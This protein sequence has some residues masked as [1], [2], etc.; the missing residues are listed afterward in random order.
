MNMTKKDEVYQYLKKLLEQGTPE[1]K[2]FNLTI[3]DL[4]EVDE[5]KGIGKTTLSNGRKLFLQEHSIFVRESDLLPKN[6]QNSANGL[7]SFLNRLKDN[8]ELLFQLLDE[9]QRRKRVEGVDLSQDESDI[10]KQKIMQEY[11][12]TIGKY[13]DG[14]SV[15]VRID[16]ELFDD[17][18]KMTDDVGLSQ[19]QAI[20][21]AIRLFNEYCMEKL[22]KKSD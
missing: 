10:V 1:K 8:E 4:Q 7:Q 19:R 11:P 17:F 21:L 14:K 18:V 6:G 22:E 9:Y 2:I 16:Q 5:L 3:K 12:M 15:G 20:H 13:K